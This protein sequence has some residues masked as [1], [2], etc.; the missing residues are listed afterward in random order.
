MDAKR[1]LLVALGGALLVFAGAALLAGVADDLPA[2]VLLA[3]AVGMLSLAIGLLGRRDERTPDTGRASSRG[4]SHVGVIAGSLAVFGVVALAVAV[5]VPVGEARGHA[6]GHLLTGV[7]ALV[8]FVLLGQLWHPA[9]SGAAAAIR[10]AVLVVLA[11]AAFGA[12]LESLGGAGYDAANAEPRI[13]ALAALHGI[14]LPIAALGLPAIPL[15]LVVA[16]VAI[17]TWTVRRRRAS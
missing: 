12:F 17:A 15:G 7:A 2:V 9:P 1:T 10:V 13:E 3:G 16:L 14:A 5:V 4:R 11:V 8:L 6:V